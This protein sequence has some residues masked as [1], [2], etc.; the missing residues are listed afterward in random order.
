MSKTG[1]CWI[2]R[3]RRKKC[4]QGRPDCQ[5]C[6]ALSIQCHYSEDRPEWMDGAEKQNEMTR[7][8]KAQ[9]RQG[10]ERRRDRDYVRVLDMGDGFAARKESTPLYTNLPDSGL[11]LR[12][13]P[14][15]KELDVDFT[16]HYIDHVF[17]FLFP[18]YAPPMIQGG[19]AW[20][21]DVLRSNETLFQAAMGLSIYFLTLVLS[22]EDIS[23][24]EVCRQN[25]WNLL[26]GHANAA[27]K[28]LQ[29]EVLAINHHQP[30]AT[31]IQQ[32]RAMESITQ[33]MVLEMSM[34]KTS[35]LNMHLAA[36]ISLFE[37]IVRP[38]MREGRLDIMR[39][40]TELERP[41]LAPLTTQRPAWGTE[42]AAFRFF[43][44]TLLRA[45][46]VSSVSLRTIPRLRKYYPDLIC[47]DY[48][49]PTVTPLLRMEEYVG[50]E[51]WVL[52]S[53]ADI[54][55]LDVWKLQEQ[56]SSMLT[57][58]DLC[59]RGDQIDCNIRSGLRGLEERCKKR[60]GEHRRILHTFFQSSDTNQTTKRAAATRIWAYA[61]R[62]YLS[63]VTL[64][65]QPH[66]QAHRE[67]VT[68]V[69]RLLKQ[70]DDPAILCSSTWPFFVAGCVADT[71]Q[72]HQFRDL[73]I[74]SGTL[75]SFGLVGTSLRLLEHV[76]S[77]R[78]EL[79][80]EWNLAAFLSMMDSPVLFL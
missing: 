31:I 24:Y 21:L 42:Q 68:E 22:I 77:R 17:P 71:S 78:E 63:I 76:W 74:A 29:E 69:L 65:W 58:E 61:A 30:K 39:V 9:V 33:L 15:A 51:G 62:I 54:S 64:G 41:A 38:H 59:K 4:D 55:A 40:M 36:A 80:E 56:E 37:D 57:P 75:Q 50:C 16:M 53:I 20:V 11:T 44:A 27:V 60:V 49:G 52:I 25:S 45:D 14:I 43:V 5:T 8:L 32:S 12:S 2:C 79:N 70:Q 1:S 6:S 34:A 10:R 67:N 72:E 26:E 3:L 7:R 13:I 46:I 28:S 23:C 35:E 66:H 48:G 19:R 18:F 47:H 73:A